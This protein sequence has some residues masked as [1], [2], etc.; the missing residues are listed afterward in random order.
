MTIFHSKTIVDNYRLVS[1]TDPDGSQ[2]IVRN[3]PTGLISINDGED[4]VIVHLGNLLQ[5]IGML[6]E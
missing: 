4:I 1:F 5:A 6:D 3:L 2:V